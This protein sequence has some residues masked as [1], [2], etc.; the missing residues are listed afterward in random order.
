VNIVA[1]HAFLA[2]AGGGP[3]FLTLVLEVFLA[4]SYRDAFRPMLAARV[5]THADASD[6]DQL[7]RGVAAQH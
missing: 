6:A 3:A 2:P 5:K 4:W 7:P 1:F